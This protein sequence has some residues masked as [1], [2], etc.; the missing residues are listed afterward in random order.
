MSHR[1]RGPAGD[2]SRASGANRRQDALEHLTV[3][4][5]AVS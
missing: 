2:A 3:M 5:E 1:A 4:A